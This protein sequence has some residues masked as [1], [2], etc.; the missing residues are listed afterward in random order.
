MSPYK[1]NFM[2]AKVTFFLLFFL[3]K[4]FLSTAVIISVSTSTELINAIIAANSGDTIE[5]AAGDY[6]ITGGTRYIRQ[7]ITIKASPLASVKPK[8]KG[9]FTI[10]GNISLALFGIE[11]FYDNYE[12]TP[13]GNHFINAQYA[14]YNIPTLSLVN[15][16]IHGYG[17][18]L[19]RADNSTYKPTIGNLIVDN[20]II[21][22]MGRHANSYS[23][24]AAQYARTSNSQI[25]NSTFY[26]CKNGIWQG[27][28]TN[29]YPI[30]FLM[31]KCCV[32][33]ITTTG[34][35][36]VL[37]ATTNPGSVYT[38]RDCIFSNS[39]DGITT[40]LQLSLGAN[41]TNHLAHLD[42]VIMI[43]DFASPKI[44][45]TILSTNNETTVDSLSYNYNNLSVTSDPDTILNIG[46][47]RWKVNLVPTFPGA[48]GGGMYTTGGRGGTV[49]YVTKLTD[50]GSEG[51]LRWALNQNYPRVIM[52]KVSGIIS[53]NS[54][55]DIR[56]GN[57]T[58]AGQSAPGNGI[59]LKTNTLLIY[60]ST[61]NVIIRFM[62]FRMGDQS[63][64]VDD[65]IW[66]RYCHNIIIDHCSMSWSVDE[67][68]SFYA[69][70]NF[71]LQWCVLTES[72]RQSIHDKQ[73]P[74]GY[75]GIWG[76]KNASFHH[77]LLSCHDSRNPRFDHS[78]VYT[79]TYPE[80]IYRGNVDFRNNVIYNWGAN[81]TYGGEG[82]KFNMVNNYYKEGP[83]SSHRN[84]FIRTYGVVSGIDYGHPHLY[85]AGNY[86]SGNPN[87]I[88]NNNWY[89]VESYNDGGTPVVQLNS[90]LTINNLSGNAHTTTHT[91]TEAFNLVL[92]NAGAFP[93][94][95][96]DLRAT[97]DAELGIATFMV[98]GVP[99][100]DWPVPSTNGIIDTQ[101]AVG[102]W[103][104]YNS[105]SAPEDM[106]NDGIPDGWLDLNYHGKNANDK[107]K[108]G[109]TYLEIYLNT[110]ANVLT[111]QDS[112]IISV[113][114]STELINAIIA[115]NSGDTLE[116]AAGDYDIT[117]GVRYIRKSITIKASPLAASKPKIKGSFTID[118]N[119]SFS[120]I[121]VEAYYDGYEETPSGNHLINAQYASYD[122][123]TL[124]L[125]NCHI[126][127]YGRSLFRADNS[128]NKPTINNL[129][130]DNCF[131]EDMGRHANSYSVFAAQYARITNACITNSTFYN[132][133]NGIWQGITTNDHA[134]SFLMENCCIFK[135][136][137]T[138]SKRVVLATTNPGSVYTIRDCIFSNSYDGISTNL[139]LSLGAN[140]TTY[141]AHLDNVIMINDFASPKITGTVLTTDNEL[142]VNSLEYNYNN[143]TI[144][145]DP[146]T[147]H[148]IGD[149]MWEVNG[150]S[151]NMSIK[152]VLPPDSSP[153]IWAYKQNNMLMINNLPFN[154]TIN[155]YSL[156][157]AL[158]YSKINSGSTFKHPIKTPCII[159]VMSEDKSIHLKI[160]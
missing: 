71:T 10:D 129:I 143:L 89:G 81:N 40:N 124:S 122:I 142:S 106:N 45:G 47:P 65:A 22:D 157:G 13:T 151:G 43:N 141:L 23:V 92:K 84:K 156:T 55:L 137:T 62:R 148:N 160:L 95:S 28:A 46:D 15:C 75:G 59:C 119:V 52:F 136:T 100:I 6:D 144:T 87:Q 107:N 79:T 120:L 8:I 102:G 78:G 85:V 5:L 112:T 37:L 131:V 12:E 111:R 58:I 31:E 3:L 121:G 147:I 20:C 76:G 135:T 19:L 101:S 146:D 128:T 86:Y 113:S 152:T 42:N 44:T 117:G 155:I 17:R 60:P 149:S 1:F 51:T 29:D 70:E 64:V 132:C 41:G 116:L 25:L 90:E 68:A 139:Q 115:A 56:Y 53:L 54:R 110:L 88:N 77:N 38:V 39:Y 35:K 61:N 98:G 66:G 9:S 133:K 118:G 48:E 125:I 72:L 130:I 16:H 82:G 83:A 7:S 158:I 108:Q 50:D 91:A 14:S 2:K 30:N 69:N 126:H 114:T 154:A 127:G 57:V 93:R 34:S 134:I 32:F 27:I 94:D 145:T 36:R 123:P 26:N 4:S 104:T 18:S 99:S 138:G 150:V 105:S 153:K 74:H 140:G 67:C 159:R 97:G 11:A 24:F 96:V 103:P 63:G 21:E 73:T 109:Y 80:N 49:L 33:K